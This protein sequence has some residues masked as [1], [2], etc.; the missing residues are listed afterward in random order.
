MSI[1][2]VRVATAQYSVSPMISLTDYERKAEDWLR[3]ALDG[4]AQLAVLPE[5]A[6]LELAQVFDKRRKPDRRSP[7][8]HNLGSQDALAGDRRRAYDPKWEVRIVE[9][10]SKWYDDLYASLSERLGL[11]VLAPSLPRRDESGRL[12]NEA[13]LFAEGR[14]LGSQAKM[15][16]TNW[17][18]QIWGVEG[19]HRLRVFDTPVGSIGITI[20]FDTE[21]PQIARSMCEAGAEILLAPTCADSVRGYHRVAIGA[22][23][24]A[25]ENLCYVV[26][27]CTIGT[28]AWSHSVGHNVG[29]AGVFTVPDLGPQPD[30]TVSLGPL[31]E[32]CWIF[33]D[34]DLSAIRRLRAS[35]QLQ[36]R[37][38][39][40]TQIGFDSTHVDRIR[41]S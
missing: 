25:H 14:K 22:R 23:A 24:R 32:P 4:G 21:F 1:H 10:L 28:V 7:D 40:Q 18:S 27:A 5:Y 34:L 16:P 6:A 36:D 11:C 29:A 38:N 26:Q 37:R 12:L 3:R 39:W 35:T 19:G 9:E 31:N 8:R 2:R 41:M 13:G 20:C 33:A 30:G 15:I 17:E